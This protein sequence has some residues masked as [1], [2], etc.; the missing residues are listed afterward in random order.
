MSSSQWCDTIVFHKFFI[1][2]FT[3]NR[4]RHDATCPPAGGVASLS[5]KS[6]LL[7]PLQPMGGGMIQ[8]DISSIQWCDSVVFHGLRPTGKG[9]RQAVFQPLV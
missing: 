2:P 1:G 6:S 5:S 8:S 9:M 3:S 4:R 7:Y